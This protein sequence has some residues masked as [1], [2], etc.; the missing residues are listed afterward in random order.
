[1]NVAIHTNCMNTRYNGKEQTD[2]PSLE[3]NFSQTSINE[4]LIYS[5]HAERINPQCY[6]NLSDSNILIL[7][8]L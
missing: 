3:K 1:M 6:G 7:R 8:C 2:K 4:I 5:T